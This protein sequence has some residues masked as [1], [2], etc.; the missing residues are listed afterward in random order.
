MA[1]S[2]IYDLEKQGIQ[3]CTPLQLDSQVSKIVKKEVDYT[4]VEPHHWLSLLIPLLAIGFG[5]PQ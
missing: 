1:F 5:P 2:D 4:V 3:D